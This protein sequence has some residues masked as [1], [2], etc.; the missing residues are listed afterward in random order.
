[1]APVPLCPAIAR[2]AMKVVPKWRVTSRN[3]SPGYASGARYPCATAP[4]ARKRYVR[5][6]ELANESSET[7]DTEWS[8][9]RPRY[10]PD[11]IPR[12]NPGI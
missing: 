1:V 5:T 2:R 6:M 10:M 3:Q 7:P 12:I 11:C 4:A 9:G 8:R